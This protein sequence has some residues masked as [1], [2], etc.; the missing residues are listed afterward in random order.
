[1]RARSP[2]AR[3]ARSSAALRTVGA[4]GLV[5]A[6]L[7]LALSMQPYL[8][9]PFTFPFLA[10]VM[11]AGWFCGIGP[12]LLAV[13]LAT[14]TVDYVFIP[15]LGAFAIRADEIPYFCAFVAIA[16]LASWLSSARRSAEESLRLARD[17][18]EG[19]VAERTAELQRANE[20]LRAEMAD[21]KR[22]QDVLRATQAELAH[23]TRAMTMGEMVASIA[24]EINQPLTGVITNA[25]ASLR[26]LDGD[27]PDLG[28][29]RDAVRRIVRDGNR[30]GGV[31]ARLRA[32]LKR[33][34]PHVAPLEVHPVIEDAISVM[35]SELRSQDVALRYEPAVDLP[36]VMADR[37][38]LEQVIVN[39]MLNG[40]EAMSET[41][42]SRRVLAI[43]T[44][45]D[46][47]GV[48][49]A[50]E[51][52]GAGI[53]PRDRDRVFEPFF[54]T[55]AEG[56]G[57]G[58]SI[59]RSIVEAHGGQLWVATETGRGATFQFTLPIARSRTAREAP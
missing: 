4:L 46:D 39:L 28:E 53:A 36:L 16:L 50:V 26:W 38:Q 2:G 9:D 5:G 23:V 47:E 29:A 3:R 10:A 34:D 49:I 11:A 57:M 42:P 58:L 35:Q 30:A 7:G 48:R 37:V 13:V 12:G 20:A 27:P 32:L 43:S 25:E 21:R 1:V 41:D 40:I 8:R 14:A 55:K 6:A 56:L 59:S 54:T 33:V 24:H 31:I 51:D 15:P 44:R 45:R 18:L 17:H 22:A 52:A 19:R